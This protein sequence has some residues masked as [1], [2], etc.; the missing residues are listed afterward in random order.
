MTSGYSGKPLAEKLGLKAPMRVALIGAPADYEIQLDTLPE[1]CEP[2]TE[3]QLSVR[4]AGA[5]RLGPEVQLDFIQLFVMKR[6]ELA[7]LL[8]QLIPLLPED[9]SGK[10]SGGGM[11][12]VSWVKQAMAKK[13]GI[14]TDITEDT[15]RD[16]ALP[17]GLVDVKVCAVDELWSGLKLVRRKG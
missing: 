4:I 9:E 3:Q 7:Y 16:V 15:V 10:T 12:W 14:D 8:P 13:L 1:G 5:R 6:S 17:L 2:V 11:L